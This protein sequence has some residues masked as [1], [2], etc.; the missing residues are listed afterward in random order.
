LVGVYFLNDGFGHFIQ[1]NFSVFIF[2]LVLR[3]IKNFG[4]DF[5]GQGVKKEVN[6]S[7]EG[8]RLDLVHK[9]AQYQNED[10]TYQPYNERVH[11]FLLDR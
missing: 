5:L 6:R 9:Y 11:E 8:I 3:V 1:N 4:L 2:L 7:L 10:S